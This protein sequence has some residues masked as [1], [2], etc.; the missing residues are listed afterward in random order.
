MAHCE[1]EYDGDGEWTGVR[2]FKHAGL[3]VGR[4]ISREK[5]TAM[6][7][8]GEPQAPTGVKVVRSLHGDPELIKPTPAD[9]ADARLLVDQAVEF[10][11]AIIVQELDGA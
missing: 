10:L 7:I 6:W 5:M 2:C 3:G 11:M 9:V 8:R 4:L 1:F